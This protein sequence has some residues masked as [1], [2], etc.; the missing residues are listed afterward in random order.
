MPQDWT[1]LVL[2]GDE[3]D[4]H[5]ELA[6]SKYSPANLRLGG[7]VGTHCVYNDV[8]RHQLGSEKL[9]GLAWAASWLLW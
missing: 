9:A 7:F 8:C 3:M 1:Q 6:G 4:P 5:A 2:G